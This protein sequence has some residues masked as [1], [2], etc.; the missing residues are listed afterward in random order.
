LHFTVRKRNDSFAW[1]LE[2]MDDAPELPLRCVESRLFGAWVRNSPMPAFANNTNALYAAAWWARYTAR[3]EAIAQAVALSKARGASESTMLH[4]D[5]V[6]WRIADPAGFEEFGPPMKK[7]QKAEEKAKLEALRAAESVLLTVYK[8]VRRAARAAAKAVLE[9]DA[10]KASQQAARAQALADVADAKLHECLDL[11]HPLSR[12]VDLMRAVRT[13]EAAAIRAARAAAG[14]EAAAAA[15]ARATAAVAAAAEA[16][17]AA[18]AAYNAAVY[19]I[20][21]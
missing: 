2:N 7:R 1:L 19:G 18:R 13:E 11:V 8:K 3:D 15:A 6:A 5:H 21:E 12:L 16:A 17:A 4:A 9:K 14:H 10:Q 20:D